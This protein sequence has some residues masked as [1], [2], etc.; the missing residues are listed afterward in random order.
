MLV[1]EGVVSMLGIVTLTLY[2][3]RALA[4]GA[5][6]SSPGRPTNG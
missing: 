4:G 2:P 1:A 5:D 6:G 3:R